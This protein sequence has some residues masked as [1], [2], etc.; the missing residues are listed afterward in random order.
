MA[1]GKIHETFWD[2]ELLRQ[3]ARQNEDTRWFMAYLLTCRHKNRLGCFVLDPRYAGADLDWAPGRAEAALELLCQ[4]G[5]VSYDPTTRVIFIH[6]FLRHNTL[7]NQKVVTGAL[8]E[9]ASIPDNPFLPDLLAA[10][11]ANKR[12]HYTPLLQA[13]GN[14]I[15]NRKGNGTPNHSETVCD[16]VAPPILS[17]SLTDNHNSNTVPIGT[18]PGAREV[19]HP[20]GKPKNG[21]NGRKTRARLPAKARATLAPAIREH[22]WNS[23]SPPEHGW[24]M[25]REFTIAAELM[26]GGVTLDELEGAIGCARRVLGFHDAV[27]LTL[28]VFY[29]AGRRDQLQVCIAAWRRSKAQERAHGSSGKPDTEGALRIV[30]GGCAVHA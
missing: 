11:E 16:T 10:L 8:A 1:Y 22:L 5:R 2:D 26:N 3:L 13:L 14:R 20:R 25:S 27:P 6:H 12:A 23:A 29:Q 30:T 18:E 19:S 15:A 9:L 28:R 17:L 24:S 21:K 7:E 4:A